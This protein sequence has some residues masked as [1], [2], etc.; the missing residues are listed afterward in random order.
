MYL[1][2]IKTS[3]IFY[4]FQEE[5]AKLQGQMDNKWIVYFLSNLEVKLMRD[6][7]L[8]VMGM[9]IGAHIKLILMEMSKKLE[10]VI[11]TVTNK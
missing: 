4:S 9:V 8:I 10:V 7:H 11:T 3:D 6:V 5:H 2:Q 1:S